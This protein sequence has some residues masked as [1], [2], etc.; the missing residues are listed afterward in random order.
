MENEIRK[1]G[2]IGS[3]YS[4]S[5]DRSSAATSS[6]LLLIQFFPA[7]FVGLVDEGKSGFHKDGGLRTEEGNIFLFWQRIEKRGREKNE[8][9]RGLEWGET[10]T[11]TFDRS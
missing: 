8:E 7:L 5:A 6:V 11:M 9:G 4:I 1:P 3:K 10:T 2:S